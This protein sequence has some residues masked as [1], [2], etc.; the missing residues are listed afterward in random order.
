MYYTGTTDTNSCS[1]PDDRRISEGEI[2]NAACNVCKCRKGEIQCTQLK[3]KDKS[4]IES[5]AL[6]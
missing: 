3:C 4:L 6:E 2:Q 1:M 5:T